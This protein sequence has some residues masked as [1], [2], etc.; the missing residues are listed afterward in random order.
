MYGAPADRKLIEFLGA[1]DPHIADLAL[2][3]RETI[4]EEAP[5][6]SESIYQVYTAAIW[7]GFSGKVTGHVLLPCGQ[8]P[9]SPL[10]RQEYGRR[11]LS[12][13]ASTALQNRAPRKPSLPA[14][15]FRVGNVP[16]LPF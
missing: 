5:G 9:P 8:C 13:E 6:A 16:S 4:L 7:F 2:A 3:L 12:P 1:Y 14:Y 15:V 10:W 11:Y